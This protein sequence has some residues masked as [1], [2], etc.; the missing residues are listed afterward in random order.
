MW[1]WEHLA[2]GYLAYSILLRATERRGPAAG[3]A[4]AV[5]LGTQFPDVVDKSFAWLTTILPGGQSLAHSLLFAIPAIVAV[6]IAAALADRTDLGVAFGIGYLSHLPGDV[7]YPVLL[8]G[9]LNLSFLLWPILAP[10]GSTPTAVFAYVQEL[11]VKFGALLATPQGIYY[12]AFEVLLL[13]VALLLWVYDGTP[14]LP[15]L[16]RRSSK[17]VP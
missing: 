2:V 12:L 11:F 7:V 1:P 8:G 4:I 17:E 6:G 13:A 3:G 14:G 15:R 16:S 5:A 9:D 10:S